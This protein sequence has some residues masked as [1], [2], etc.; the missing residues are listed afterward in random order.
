MY[1]HYC[2]IEKKGFSGNDLKLSI[3]VSDCV[4]SLSLKLSFTATRQLV[5]LENSQC[6]NVPT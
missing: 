6:E 1:M 5:V 3:S 4:S 2:L